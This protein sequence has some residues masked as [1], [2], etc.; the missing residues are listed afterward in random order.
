MRVYLPCREEYEIY[1]SSGS[2]AFQK[3]ME[4][5]GLRLKGEANMEKINFS[6]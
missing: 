2:G 3:K 6:G 5:E 1:L 4:G